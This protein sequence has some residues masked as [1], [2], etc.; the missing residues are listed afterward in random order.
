MAARLMRAVSRTLRVE[1]H[2][3]CGFLEQRPGHALI[4]VLWHNAIF[5]WPHLY[6]RHW[7]ER[8]GAAL[9]S[10]SRDGEVVAGVLEAFGIAPVRGSSSRRGMAAI[11][12]LKQWL[13]DGHDIAIT[14]DGPRG[15]KYHLQP[16]LVLLAQKTKIPILPYRILYDRPW[17]LK[18]WDQFQIPRPFS[19]LE[20]HIGPY[21]EVPETL[22]ED[23]FAR[24]RKRI[25]EALRLGLPDVPEEVEA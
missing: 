14:P 19:R 20:V 11:I 3:H 18:T 7:P 23:A 10:A 16:G 21:L 2:D 15:P 8:H 12:E 9:T 13:R 17:R 22:D 24:E 4:H 6:Q 5:A 25:E 1:F